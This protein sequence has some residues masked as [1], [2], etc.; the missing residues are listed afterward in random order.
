MRTSSHADWIITLWAP[1]RVSL[2]E[3]STDS[4]DEAAD[5][6]YAARRDRLQWPA[7]SSHVR[8]LQF[9]KSQAKAQT[10]PLEQ[11]RVTGRPYSRELL[12][13][14]RPGLRRV[15]AQHALQEFAGRGDDLAS[16]MLTAERVLKLLLRT[17]VL[18][19]LRGIGRVD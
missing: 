18:L 8:V 16:L 11:Q 3:P 13:H 10:I 14:R 12:K 4:Q 19:K 6:V 2:R 7:Q 5:G 15:R 1:A 17:P 9:Q